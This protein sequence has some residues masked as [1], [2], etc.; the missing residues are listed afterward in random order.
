M[1]ECREGRVAAVKWIVLYYVL[2]VSVR[3]YHFNDTDES[4]NR[5]ENSGIRQFWESVLCDWMT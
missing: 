3:F 4:G 5:E 1:D 2:V